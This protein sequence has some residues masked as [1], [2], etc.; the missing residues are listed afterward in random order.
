MQYKVYTCAM[1]HQTERKKKSWLSSALKCTSKREKRLPEISQTNYT[2]VIKLM[3]R[4]V[5][6]AYFSHCFMVF[7]YTHNMIFHRSEPLSMSIY[8]FFSYTH[9]YCTLDELWDDAAGFSCDVYMGICVMYIKTRRHSMVALAILF[10]EWFDHCVFSNFFFGYFFC[11]LR[12]I[13]SSPYFLCVCSWFHIVIPFG[14]I[15]NDGSLFRLVHWDVK[16]M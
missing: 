10:H 6:H 13:F 12:D 2:I 1:K 9:L 11:V 3:V 16:K 4:K 15:I 5:K 7:I 14:I 8:I